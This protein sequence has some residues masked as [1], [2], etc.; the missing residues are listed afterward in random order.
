[1]LRT[2]LLA[3][4]LSLPTAA[5]LAPRAGAAETPT[6][7]IS[8]S[9]SIALGLA[10]ISGPDGAALTQAV[11]RHLSLLGYFSVV[12]AGKAPMTASGASSG[13]SL[14]GKVADYSGSTVLQRSYSG[15]TREQAIAF[16]NDIVE[17]LTGKPGIAGSRIAFVGT[18]TGK[19]EL[20]TADYDGTNVKQMT[21]DGNISVAPALAPGGRKLAY[22]GY[23]KGY[24]DIYVIDLGSG[25]RQRIVKFPGTNSGAAF[26]PNGSQIACS[27]SRDGNPE[28][29]V[30]GANGGGARRLTKTRGVESSPSWS[31]DGSEIVYSSD[32]GGGPQL[33]RISASGGSGRLLSTGFGYCTEPSWSP[34]GKKIAFN[35]RQGGS[36]RV[37]V[38]DLGS[39]ATRILSGA[40]DDARDPA[41][42]PDSRHLIYAKGNG[43]YLIDSQ[44]NRSSRLIDNLGG[45]SEPTWA[46]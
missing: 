7:T 12:E 35:V 18:R 41:W 1:M 39:G 6:I 13:G 43:L 5:V 10:P 30:V 25:S 29:Y 27:I 9:D 37:A 46:R 17:T 14:Q 23:L 15:G 32:Q 2:L 33:Y 42:G 21:H 26:S 28:L 36:F 4:A 16:A 38:L 8:K 22:T 19:K 20:Y 24:A 11:R 34:D 31:P 44:T 3:A 45:I 40:G